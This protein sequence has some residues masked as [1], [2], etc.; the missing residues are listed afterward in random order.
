MFPK[1]PR[2][3]KR[4]EGRRFIKVNHPGLMRIEV[5]KT[6]RAEEIARECGHFSVAR[7]LNFN[8]EKGEAEFEHIDDLVPIE[9]AFSAGMETQ[10]TLARAGAALGAIHRD[11]RLPEEM[12]HS[13]PT[14]IDGPGSSVFLHGDFNVRNV[15]VSEGLKKIFIF[16]WQTTLQLDPWSTFGSRYIDVAWFVNSMFSRPFQR[17]LIGN[18]AFRGAESF[19]NAYCDEVGQLFVYEDFRSF[20]SVFL[21]SRVRASKQRNEL[22]G[23]FTSKVRDARLKKFMNKLANTQLKTTN[24]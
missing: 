3:A 19:L 17:W 23:R 24:G 15:C 13:F 9:R 6:I 18:A 4:V 22:V 12:A 5:E 11:L 10:A 8:P 16:D 21:K 2:K 14:D 1:D 20:M 7:V